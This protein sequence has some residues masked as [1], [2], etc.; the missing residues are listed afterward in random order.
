MRNR[1]F[2]LAILAAVSLVVP[3]TV[4]FAQDLTLP[5][6]LASGPAYEVPDRLLAS[7]A[8]LALTESEAT[9][10]AALS[11]DF[12]AQERYWQRLQALSAKPWIVALRRPS[13]QQAFDRALKTLT[14]SQR[15]AAVRALAST[16]G[17]IR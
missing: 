16:Q 2:R 4:S 15:A 7:R 1:I 14:P 11:A 3:G 8:E 10:L 17:I 12:Q 9:E 5:R 13:P 6:L